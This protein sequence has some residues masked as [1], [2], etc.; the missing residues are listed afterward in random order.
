M[1]WFCCSTVGVKNR[2]ENIFEKNGMIVKTAARIS[3]L[4]VSG[5]C[6]RHFS[7]AYVN[8]EV[9]SNLKN[10]AKTILAQSNP[11]LSEKLPLKPQKHT[12]E[13]PFAQPYYPLDLPQ[14]QRALFRPLVSTNNEISGEQALSLGAMCIEFTFTKY[15]LRTRPHTSE[16]AVQNFITRA[17]GTLLEV[18]GTDESSLFET[19]G[20]YCYLK[21]QECEQYLVSLIAENARTAELGTLF[22]RYFNTIASSSHRIDDTLIWNTSIVN[23][24]AEF[25]ILEDSSVFNEAYLFSLTTLNKVT[26]SLIHGDK[27]KILEKHHQLYNFG[28][29]S[30]TYYT[31]L[32]A[33]K[34]IP[35]TEKVLE[36]I[37]SIAEHTMSFIKFSGVR[38]ISLSPETATILR[39]QG[40]PTN[41]FFFRYLG[42]LEIENSQPCVQ[43]IDSIVSKSHSG[44]LNQMFSKRFNQFESKHA[45]RLPKV[46][47]SSFN[48]VQLKTLERL[49]QL[50]VSLA[51]SSHALSSDLLHYTEYRNKIHSQL[52]SIIGE[53]K[54]DSQVLGYHS[55]HNL[56]LVF[57]ILG[58]TT[59][60]SPN[61]IFNLKHL[62]SARS[63]PRMAIDP[64]FKLHRESPLSLP[65]LE[66]SS[67]ITRLLMVNSSIILTKSSSSLKSW[68]NDRILKNSLY[69]WSSHGQLIFD[70]FWSRALYKNF[71]DDYM[72]H[73]EDVYKLIKSNAYK[74]FALDSA[75]VFTGLIDDKQYS[76]VLA[77]NSDASALIHT[78]FGQ[79][80]SA[81]HI[82]DVN[83]VQNWTNRLAEFVVQLFNAH[84]VEDISS[85]TIALDEELKS[86]D[87]S[88]N[89]AS[90]EN[91]FS[92]L[93][94][95]F[96]E[97]EKNA[98]EFSQRQVQS[99]LQFIIDKL[100]LNER[101]PVFIDKRERMVS[102]LNDGIKVKGFRTALVNAVGDKKLFSKHLESAWGTRFS[103]F[104]LRVPDLDLILLAGPKPTKFYCW[105]TELVLPRV[106][107]TN[108]HKL[109]LVNY[110]QSR[111]F[112]AR[113]GIKTKNVHELP[114]TCTKFG[115]LGG[116]YYDYLIS[117]H[118]EKHFPQDVADAVISLLQD[119]KFL[120]AICSRSGILYRPFELEYYTRLMEDNITNEYYFLR[121]SSQS[122]RQYFGLIALQSPQL[123]EEWVSAVVEKLTTKHAEQMVLQLAKAI[124]DVVFRSH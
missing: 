119:R 115:T 15:I 4:T 101:L 28:K 34:Q 110:Y 116:D 94:Q 62:C 6:W 81:L 105:D 44:S 82:D 95:K 46:D 12:K 73:I 16:K 98:V 39:K 23:V 53:T 111:T 71:K 76:N 85:L 31:T 50:T 122:F 9:S 57:R 56:E 112:L 18:I 74:A 97:N 100:L 52:Q 30:F 45:A 11:L 91:Q 27:R 120:A 102:F 26:E 21:Q 67:R 41:D 24:D 93:G 1:Y 86:Y 51:A 123:A 63:I 59:N 96:V 92:K 87:F 10:V 17:R 19:I 37:D 107:P 66:D 77:S 48:D 68:K 78:Q 29:L 7:T 32:C 14:L 25:P 117:R 70:Y 118:V 83:T 108:L 65:E 13:V 114:D 40:E 43:W 58:L 8:K 5:R 47:L 79:Y 89:K 124:D 55:F 84:R 42:L 54:S 99:Y 80:I 103:P 113:N 38:K 3:P 22:G 33:L 109:L 2:I 36:A 20:H 106:E 49:G 88:L 64:D 75:N 104:K 61:S 60:M 90:K 72:G 69:A 35:E 121:Y